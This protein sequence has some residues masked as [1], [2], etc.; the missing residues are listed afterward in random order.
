MEQD[1]LAESASQSTTTINL[2]KVK[3]AVNLLFSSSHTCPRFTVP[4]PLFSLSVVTLCNTL[5]SQMKT[6]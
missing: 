5:N 3:N 1:L 2:V 4:L 6:A